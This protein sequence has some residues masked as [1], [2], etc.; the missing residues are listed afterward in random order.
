M[1]FVRAVHLRVPAAAAKP[2]PAIG[3]ALG[4]LGI[5][6]AQFCKDF[7]DKSA[8]IYEKD[9]PLRVELRA[10]SDRS[11]TF[12][13]RS[14][15]TSWLVKRAAGLQKGPNSP[16]DQTIAGYI[17]PEMVHYIALVKQGDD[18]TWHL[19]LEGLARQ[20]V[21]T[22]KSMGVKVVEEEDIP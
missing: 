17:T 3:Q 9:T 12:S 19:P 4:P 13:I 8:E 21:G 20:V 22:A 16:S 14:P 7:N 6:M 2:G 18:N 11:Y 5:N 1:S 15:P 10:M